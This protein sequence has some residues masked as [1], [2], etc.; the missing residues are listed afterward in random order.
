MQNKKTILL[1]GILCFCFS[2]LM[3]QNNHRH[4]H[5]HNEGHHSH[6]KTMVG[7]TYLVHYTDKDYKFT[8]VT[9]STI[10]WMDAK[11]TDGPVYDLTTVNHSTYLSWWDERKEGSMA[12]VIDLRHK[13]IYT[14]KVNENRKMVQVTGTLTFVPDTSNTTAPP[15]ATPTLTTPAKK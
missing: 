5:P 13:K 2:G 4:K 1:A 9:D 12:Q 8:F 14:T 11:A 7:K 15:V 6:Y 10:K 3:A